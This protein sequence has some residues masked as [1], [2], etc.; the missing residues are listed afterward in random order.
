M[1][2]KI[3]KRFILFNLIVISIV[4]LIVFL[5]MLLDFS[6]EHAH[7]GTEGPWEHRLITTFILFLVLALIASI[8]LANLAIRPIQEAW[9]KQL[10]FTADASHELR[11]PLAVIQTSLEII[12]DNQDETVKSQEMWLSN[13]E[14]E[15]KRMA[16]LVEDLL[17]LS[18]GDTNEQVLE[19]EV[20]DLLEL[21][22]IIKLTL[23]PVA[24][25][26]GIRIESRERG[27]VFFCGDSKRMEQL[28]V[29]LVDNA[30]KYMGRPGTIMLESGI[31]SGRMGKKD[32]I[33][34][35]VKDDGMGMDEKTV[36]HVFERFYRADDKR[37]EEGSGLGLS[38]ARWIV[39]SHGGK[40]RAE[41]EKGKGTCFT[42]YLPWN[43]MEKEK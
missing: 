25:K 10:D 2:K 3:K 12:M 31:Q 6:G 11:T 43:T 7:R 5:V 29:I 13:I 39:E 34:L 9:K 41:S 37:S 36:S 33:V 24:A 4:F 32:W 35:K 8:F 16:K 27:A 19:K 23:G 28:L 40:I 15:Q 42:I 21:M 18:R 38:I 30:V 1:I 26:K 14:I 22:E 17:T 20:I